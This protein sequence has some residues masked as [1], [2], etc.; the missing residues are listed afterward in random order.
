MN[1]II[2]Y[3]FND[4]CRLNTPLRCSD[5]VRRGVPLTETDVAQPRTLVRFR[6]Q[7]WRYA[8]LVKQS[9]NMFPAILGHDPR[10]RLG[11]VTTGASFTACYPAHLEP[12]IPITG[13]ISPGRNRHARH[14]DGCSAI[15][16]MPANARPAPMTSQRVSGIPS[17]KRSHSSATAIYMP[18]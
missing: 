2:A 7:K 18:P 3:A 6:R 13:S 4:G 14:A 15:I 10:N 17:T 5:Q 11:T 8:D 12:G 16:A 1:T 9:Q